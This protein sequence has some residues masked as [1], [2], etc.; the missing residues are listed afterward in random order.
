MLIRFFRWLLGYVKFSYIGGFRE[1]FINDC[2]EQGI[3]LKN[4]CVKNGEL[5][6]EAKIKTYKALHRIAFSHG[7]RVKIFKRKGFPFLLSP[8]NNRW[9]FF[10]GILYLVFFVSFMGGFVWNITVSGNNR[11]T[12][13]KIVDYLA[14]NGFKIGTRWDSID[15]EQLEIAIMADFEDVAWISINKIGS[16]ASIEINETVNKPKLVDNNKTTNVKAA[17]DGVIVRLEVLGG[18]AAV[19]EGEAVTAGDLLISGVRESEVDEKNHYTHAYGSVFAE[20]EDEISINI[21]RNQ[22][23]RISTYSKDY[24]S[25]FIFG[26]ELPFYFQKDLG[27][28][29]EETDK[30]YL[31]INKYRLPIGIIKNHCDYFK[32]QTV[33]ISDAELETLAKSELEKKKKEELAGCEILSEDVRIDMRDDGCTITGKYKYIQDIGEE[34]ELLFSK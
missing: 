17:K 30:T 18:W 32:T 22:D 2:Y 33:S 27:N 7:G 12:E 14:K 21:S 23:E 11:V 13:V 25:L 6:A 10:V 8:L 26:M 5:T 24:N 9:G 15:K 3:Y 4:I 29:I 28:A 20:V 19:Q 34:T 31:V 1:D 16:T